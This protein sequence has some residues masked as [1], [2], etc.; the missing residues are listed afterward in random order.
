MLLGELVRDRKVPQKFGEVKVIVYERVPKKLEDAFSYGDIWLK[1]DL[2]LYIPNDPINL[3]IFPFFDLESL[4]HCLFRRTHFREE[5]Q[6]SYSKGGA[7]APQK[8]RSNPVDVLHR[9]LYWLG[10]CKEHGP[11]LH[12]FSIL[13]ESEKDQIMKLYVD[14]FMDPLLSQLGGS[15]RF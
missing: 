14:G 6:G 10:Q 2:K 9:D 8:W 13:S 1:K 15:V 5:D 7:Y 3:E 11:F 4:A 12:D